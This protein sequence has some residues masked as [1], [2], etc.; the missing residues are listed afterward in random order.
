MKLGISC[1]NHMSIFR[2]L[3]KLLTYMLYD[4]KNDYEKKIRK[5]IMRE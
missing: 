1:D 5:K 2:P 4:F 3:S